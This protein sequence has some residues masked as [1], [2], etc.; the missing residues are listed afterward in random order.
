[1][2]KITVFALLLLCLALAASMVSCQ[3]LFGGDVTETEAGWTCSCG[4]V[5][6][7]KFCSECGSPKPEPGTTD[8]PTEAVTDVPTDKATEE[9]TEKGTEKPTEADTEPVT[10]A[11]R[12]DYF[13]ADV[14]ADVT[15]DKSVYTDMQLKLPADLQVTDKDV[16]DYVDYVLFQYR[17]ADNGSTQ[18]KD[19]PMKLGDDAFIYYKGVIDGKEFEGGSNWD[20]ATPRKL[21]LGS[22]SFIPGFEEGLVGV[23]PQNATKE[24]PV[25]VH[26]T[27]PED[28]TAELAGKDAVFYVAVEYAIQYTVPVYNRETVEKVLQYKGEKDF[29]ASDAA[30]LSEF[31]GYIRTTLEQKIAGDLEYAKTSAIWEYLTTTATCVN[32][33]QLEL[34]YYYNAYLEEVEYYYEYYGQYGGAS[35][36]EQFPDMDAFARNY[37][38]VEE[39]GDWKAE[40]RKIAEDMVKKD[41]IVH[42]I[43]EL[44]GLE[45]ITEKEFDD[46]VQYWVDYYQGYMSKDEVLKNFGE[47]AIREG[48]LLNKMQT[49]LLEHATFTFEAE[50]AAA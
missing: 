8:A 2:K 10:L 21:G 22:G 5:N 6:E 7:G 24:S 33:P 30:Y 16:A 45:A 29:Y 31:E 13:D 26:V 15:V 18:V 43:A 1:M 48:A 34:D 25:E 36:K 12:Y 4:E 17:S 27:F 14:K 11:P 50:N 37:V 35:F 42:A 41:M 9:T 3:S 32:L 28:Y 46:E 23:I 47:N 19:K 44:E 38:G 39:G 20:A 40:L 49:W